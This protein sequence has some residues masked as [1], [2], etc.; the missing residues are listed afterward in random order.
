MARPVPA[1]K[2][3]IEEYYRRM[4]MAGTTELTADEEAALKEAMYKQI[5]ANLWEPHSKVVPYKTKPVQYGGS[6]CR[7]V[8]NDWRG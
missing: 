1:E 7:T 5:A 4:E 6:C 8:S 3:L 2:A